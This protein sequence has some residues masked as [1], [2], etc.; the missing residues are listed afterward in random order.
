[1]LALNFAPPPETT[2]PGVT[3]RRVWAHPEL[4]SHSLCVLTFDRL[5]LAPLAGSPKPETVGAVE[6]GADLDLL[7]GPLTTVLDLDAVRQLKLDLLTNTVVI[8]YA[9]RGDTTRRVVVT[10]ATPEAADMCF[11][12][13]WRRLGMDFT[14]SPYARDTWSLVRGPL[15]LLLGILLMTALAVAAISLFEDAGPQPTATT[16]FSWK[17]VCALGGIAAAASQVWLYRR[18][19]TPPVALELV[20]R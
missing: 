3:R 17:T 5:Y 16:G 13:L 15:L 2:L 14:L 11:T 6:A 20:R 4:C 18:L 7:L 9:G 1:M 10:F 8:E 19:T 12:R